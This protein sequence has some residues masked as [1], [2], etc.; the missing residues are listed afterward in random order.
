MG[1]GVLQ[2]SFSIKI[3]IRMAHA[4]IPCSAHFFSFLLNSKK[5]N[6]VPKKEFFSLFLLFL[7]LS[8]YECIVFIS[9]YYRDFF[10][11]SYKWT[12]AYIIMCVSVYLVY[13]FLTFQPSTFWLILI[14]S[15][16]S[17]AS[18]VIIIAII[19]IA[20]QLTLLFLDCCLLS[21]QY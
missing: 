5:A 10:G 18:C 15:K 16:D 14:T 21:L 9:F 17:R 8:T 11:T 7:L 4:G 2:V 12:I 6:P 3:L 20:V 19:A 13:A 1:S